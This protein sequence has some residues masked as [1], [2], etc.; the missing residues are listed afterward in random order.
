MDDT[1]LDEMNLPLSNPQEELE[2]ISKNQLMPLFDPARFEVRSED[3]RDKGI[4]LHIELKKA[5]KHTNIRFA[6]QLKATESKNTNKDGTISLQIQTSNINYLLNN[7]GPAYYVLYFKSTGTFYYENLNDF[8][9]T[10]SEKQ[11]DWKKQQSHVLRFTKLLTK[12]TI[13]KIYAQTLQKGIFHRKVNE[14]LILQSASIPSADRIMVDADLNIAEDS[15]IRSLIE[16]A[17]LMLIN[18]ARWK[19]VIALHKNGS[20]SI[21]STAKYN[22][23]LGMA[24]YYNGNHVDAL[25]FLKSAQR[26]RAELPADLSIHLEYFLISV[27]HSLGLATDQDYMKKIDELEGTD[28]VG[29]YIRIEKAKTEYLK[30]LSGNEE[31]NY[32]KLL[33]DIQTVLS[34]PK[35]DNALRYFAEGEMVIIRGSKNNWEYVKKIAMINAKE[36]MTGPDR[37]LRRDAYDKFSA[38]YDSWLE[39][40]NKLTQETYRKGNYLHYLHALINEVKVIYEMTVFLKE[41]RIQYSI[42][43]MPELRMTDEPS[44]FTN[45]L[46][47]VETA[48]KFYRQIGHI[49]N[50]VVALSLRYELEHYLGDYAKASVTIAEAENIIDIYELPDKKRRLDFLKNKGTTHEQ[51]IA[52]IARLADKAQEERKEVES[53]IRDM[54]KMDEEERKEKSPKD[55]HLNIHLIP[56]GFFQFPET[57]KAKVYEILNIQDEQLKK[58][59]DHLFTFIIPVVNIHYSSITQEGPMNGNLADKGIESWRNIYRVRKAFYDNKFYRDESIP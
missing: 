51:I 42:P 59:F 52:W 46:T 25:S 53:M 35:A 17:G 9:T 31:D 29:L 36:A 6:I 39:A 57:Q 11:I 24:Y 58:H 14:R 38:S 30:N 48:L 56:I 16:T 23:L 28:S 4:D 7:P 40:L 5:N 32:N 41:I 10:L 21:A 54:Q 13:E 8:V 37:E 34:H 27:R 15:K 18:E 33:S 43:G 50:E 22:L 2:T 45:L 1:F 49:E 44:L 26:L 47:K 3:Y 19:D 20:Q 55:D 12:D